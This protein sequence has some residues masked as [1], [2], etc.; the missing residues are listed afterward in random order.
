MVRLNASSGAVEVF[1]DSGVLQW[2]GKPLGYDASVVLPI[3]G[4][5]DAI[6]MLNPDACRAGSF[7]NL[8][9]VSADGSVMWRAELPGRQGDDAYVAVRWAG[10]Q[11]LANTWSTYLVRLDVDTGR[12][13]ESTFTK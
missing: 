4:T 10:A 2:S 6:V 12:I 5:N 7:Q 13:L 1:N 11:L 8:L 3:G 9:R